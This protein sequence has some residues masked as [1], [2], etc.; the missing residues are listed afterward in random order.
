M[1]IKQFI[2]NS[3]KVILILAITI[4]LAFA[5]ILATQ[6]GFGHIGRGSDFWKLVG[7][8]SILLSVPW[9]GFVVVP[10]SYKVTLMLRKFVKELSNPVKNTDMTIIQA[11]SNTAKVVLIGVITIVLAVLVVMSVAILTQ[12]LDLDYNKDVW[13]IV[14]MLAS[15]LALPW[16]IFIVAPLSAKAVHSLYM[17]VTNLK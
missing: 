1:T 3:F 15:S 12:D 8:L 6:L 14:C 5:L 11:I 9:Y 17:F 13:A 4:V 2:I 16:L 7:M 10:L